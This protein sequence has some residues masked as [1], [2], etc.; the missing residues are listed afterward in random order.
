M[1]SVFKCVW[2]HSCLVKNWGIIRYEEAT[3][4]GKAKKA[5]PQTGSIFVTNKSGG[6]VV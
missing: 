5:A 1:T 4:K 6:T 3:E 2:T